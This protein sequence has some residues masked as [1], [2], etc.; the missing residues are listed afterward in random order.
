MKR[1]EDAEADNDNILAVVLSAATDH[2]AE[3]VSITHPHDEA[4]AHLYTQV[5]RRAGIDPLAVG[6]VEM[7]GTGTQ[8]GDKTE[9]KSVT[10]VFAPE[11]GRSRAHDVPLHIGTVKC[12]VGHGEAAA[13]IMAFIKTMLVFQKGIIPPHIGIK[14]RLNP[15]LPDLTNRNV[16]IPYTAT[17]WEPG[18]KPRLAMVNNFGAAGGN[19]SIIVEE[20]KPRPRIGEDTRQAQVITVSAKTAISLHENLKR[21]VDYIQTKEDVSIK[22]L[23]YTLTARRSHYNYQVSI[24]ATSRTE[25]VDL[26]RPHIETSLAQK[27]HSGK[28]PL[29]IFAFTGQGTFY[30]GIGKQLYRDSSLF[31]QQLDQ[32]DSL[33]RRQN[34]SSFLPIVAG[35]CEPDDVSTASMHVAIVCVEIALARLW[36]SFGVK[37]SAVIGHSLGEYA[38]LAVAGVL[39]D[40]VAIFLVG[41]RALLLD[42]KC[43]SYTHGMLSVRTSVANIVEAADGLPVEVACINSP[44]E[45]VVGGSTTDLDALSAALATAG[46]RTFKLQ[47]AHAYHTRQMDALLNEFVEQTQA[48]VYKKPSVPIVSPRHAKVLSSL[49]KVDISYLAAA[50]RE[51]VDF[52]GALN[53]AWDTGVVSDSTIWLEIGHHPTLCGFISR[54]L[55][56]TRLACSSLHRDDDNWKTMAK[57]LCALSNAEMDLDWDA[58]H[59]PF[60]Q[61]LRLVDAPTYAWNNKNYW[62]QYRG[63]W[64]LTKGRAEAE[65]RPAAAV[66]GFSTSSIHQLLSE[67]YDGTTAQIMAESSI[68]DPSLQGVVDGH[69]MNG[70]GVASSVNHYRHPNTLGIA[71]TPY[72][73]S[74]PRWHSLWQNAYVTRHCRARPSVGSMS[75]ISSI[76]SQWSSGKALMILSSLVLLQRLT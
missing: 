69:A 59:R 13:G 75:E 58:Y 64:N 50:T 28:Q 40:S 4:Q 61:S 11:N 17:S 1:F 74:T 43:T 8:A 53:V 7:H 15:T 76:T 24:L 36:T 73:F 25:A 2:S 33:A 57:A 12:N 30:V 48:V 42:S 5:V 51:K 29:V 26:L 37:P 70:Y 62:I 23:S 31:R 21:L 27:P 55:P 44:N 52:A 56:A 32:L 35:T 65:I 22:D 20:A 45:T 68:T 38:A 54:T 6:Y 41:T 3:A 46:H 72:S 71:L 39:S 63:E 34:F 60:E 14:T 18:K 49:D 16:V 9:M 10:S 19:T 67:R 47:V 66:K